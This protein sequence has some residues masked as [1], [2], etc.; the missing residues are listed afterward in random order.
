LRRCQPEPEDGQIGRKAFAKIAV[1][2][3]RGNVYSVTYG[4]LR[5]SDAGS[6][7]AAPRPRTAGLLACSPVTVIPKIQEDADLDRKLA[8]V[9]EWLN[10]FEPRRWLSSGH[11]QT[12][13]G[14]FLPR[15]AFQLPFTAETVEVDASDGSRVLC[16]CHWQA[17]PVRSARLTA[18]LVHGLE[19]SSDS[20]YIRGIATRAWA[21]G[22]NVVRMNMRNCGGSETLTPTLYHSGLSADVGAVVEHFTR[23]H[24]LQRV[25]LIGYSM[26]GNL[27]LKLAGE[28]GC[29]SPLAAVATVCPAIDLAAGA[30]ALHEPANRIYEMHFLRN[31]MRRFRR[32][33]ALFPAIY[34]TVG[35]G[36]VRSIR[37]FDDKIVAPYCGFCNADD[38]YHRAAS[39]RM[40]DRIAVPTLIL[41]AQDDPFIRLFSETRARLLA[42]PHITFLETRHGG[43][44]A[45][46]GAS[47]G[48]DIHWAEA[49][50]VRYILNVTADPFPR[51]S[52]S[53]PPPSKLQ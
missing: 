30:D 39:A 50:A 37:E 34:R 6:P 31:L 28:W 53:E 2:G 11:V 49:A 36:P 5:A 44:C 20:R 45:F 15:P 4:R 7:P 21:A 32:K 16:H 25:A 40:I 51:E 19:G 1:V 43:H 46:L 23:I 48:D 26:G 17:E 33:A 18:V 9:P 24:G 29:R 42:N 13:V 27:V 14:N 3:S 8:Q 10:S 52:L 41:C 35:I 38:Y 22:M 12:V 47:P